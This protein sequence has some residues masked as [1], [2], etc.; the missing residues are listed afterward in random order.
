MAE[1]DEDS[2]GEKTPEKNTP[3]TASANEEADLQFEK[4]HQGG[5]T[6][7]DGHAEMIQP[8]RTSRIASFHGTSTLYPGWLHFR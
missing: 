5:C 1:S 8:K 7:G 4:N 3:R 2:L 6:S